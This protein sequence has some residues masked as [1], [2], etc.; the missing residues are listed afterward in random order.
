MGGSVWSDAVYATNTADKAARGVPTFDHD[1][2]VKTGR[3]SGVHDTLNIHNKI[4]EA[5]DSAAHPESV[6]IGVI[7]DVTGSMCG[8]PRVMQEKLPQLMGLLLRKGYV[9]DPQIC[10][11]AIGD[12]YADKTPLQVGQFESGVEMDDNLTKV[13]LEGGGGGSYQESYQNAL[14]VF[15]HRVVTDAWEKRGKKGYLYLIGDEMP[16]DRS[17]RTELHHLVSDDVESDVLLDRILTD[18]KE[19]WH[20][21]FIIPK[22]T[23]HADDPIL[24]RRWQELLGEQNVI[25]LDDPAAVCEAIA[26]S[27]GVME[28][29]VAG[30][31]IADELRDAGADHAIVSSVTSALDPLAQN[32]ALARVGSS[33]GAIAEAPGRSSTTERL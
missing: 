1:H 19:R 11:G 22:G 13:V 32:A 9:R 26:L 24:K 6:P 23:A 3:A 28:G 25:V 31:A 21:F 20:V 30:D 7:F 4:R 5:R 17:T 12:T 15:G 33:S 10:F 8:V 18:V 29:T 14:Y 16:Y 27:I 2:A